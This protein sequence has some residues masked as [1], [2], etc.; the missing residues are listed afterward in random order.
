MIVRQQAAEIIRLADAAE[1]GLAG[2]HCLEF[3][4]RAAAEIGLA[5]DGFRRGR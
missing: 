3:L 1:R 4:A 5:P 2:Q